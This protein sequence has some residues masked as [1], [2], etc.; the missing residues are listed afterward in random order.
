ML[1]KAVPKSERE[2]LFTDFIKEKDKK[3]R[4]AKKAERKRRKGAFWA[5]LEKT[6]SIKVTKARGCE[7]PSCPKMWKHLCI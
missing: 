6:P 4:D 1:V 7:I 2:P 3:E 5:L